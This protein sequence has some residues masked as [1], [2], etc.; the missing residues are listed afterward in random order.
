MID[1]NVN[2]NP[3]QVLTTGQSVGQCVGLS[4]SSSQIQVQISCW[5]TNI[6]L[7]IFISWLDI[8]QKWNW[9]NWVVKTISKQFRPFV[10]NCGVLGVLSLKNSKGVP[11]S[12]TRGYSEHSW[13]IKKM[14]ALKAPK[15]SKIERIVCWCHFTRLPKQNKVSYFKIFK[16]IKKKAE[17]TLFLFRIAPHPTYLCGKRRGRDIRLE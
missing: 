7:F 15:V 11:N 12:P 4:F 17:K 14:G 13:S 9:V 8:I 1:V 2:T 16:V 5:S 6:F 10:V 3:Y